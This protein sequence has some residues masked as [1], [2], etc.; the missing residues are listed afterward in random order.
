MAR[1]GFAVISLLILMP[2][3][4]LCAQTSAPPKV[5][6]GRDVLPIFRQQCGDCHGPAKQRAGMRLDRRSSAMK[7]FTRRIVPGSS[8]NSFVYYRIAGDSFG[9]QMP[10]TGALRPEQIATI[11]AW[12][13]QGADWPA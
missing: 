7:S 10:P 8:A 1:S 6:F 11:K 9:P 3:G 2:A 12:I 13:D 4:V 5:D